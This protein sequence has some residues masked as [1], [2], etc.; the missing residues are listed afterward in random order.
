[1]DRARQMQVRL[2]LRPYNVDLVW[3]KWSGGARGKGTETI[4][5]REPL[6]PT[7][8]VTLQI[9][10]ESTAG[11]YNESGSMTVTEISV[12]YTSDE[13]SG[14]LSKRICELHCV[15]EVPQPYDFYYE[16]TE[17]G[18]GDDP[19]ARRKFMI[20]GAPAREAFQWTVKLERMSVDN[21]RNGKPE[22][23]PK[24]RKKPFEGLDGEEDV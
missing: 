13:L 14:I 1:M 8:V 12:R 3:S 19:A 21:K 6:T 5:V 7:P 9:D 22:G 2:G 16:V 15:E 18:R 23:E 10:R 11:G 20:A 24:A 17:D 4:V